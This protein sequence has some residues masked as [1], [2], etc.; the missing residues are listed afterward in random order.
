M[1]GDSP[2]SSRSVRL[3]ETTDERIVPRR[4]YVNYTDR[5]MFHM[6]AAGTVENS[7]VP[8]LGLHESPPVASQIV[9]RLESARDQ[10]TP[11]PL[12]AG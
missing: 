12:R 9:D 11:A 3:M 5:L 4:Y 8:P 2:W 10:G 1:V 7:D 6:G